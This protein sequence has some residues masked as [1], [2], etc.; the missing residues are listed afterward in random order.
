MSYFDPRG[1]PG[2][3]STTPDLAAGSPVACPSC[4]SASITTTAKNPNSE[5]YWRCKS[6]G[7]IWNNSRRQAARRGASVWR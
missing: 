1:D 6:C 7:D 2:P 3:R 5:S 4:R